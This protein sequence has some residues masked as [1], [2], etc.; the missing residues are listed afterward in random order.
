MSSNSPP[1]S[2]LALSLRP[3]IPRLPS[4]LRPRKMA[5]SRPPSTLPYFR[6]SQ[7]LPVSILASPS[8][9]YSLIPARLQRNR[10]RTI[11]SFTFR[12]SSSPLPLY[13]RPIRR[14]EVK[15]CRSRR[16]SS[17]PPPDR[18][19]SIDSSS[20]I[21]PLSEWETPRRRTDPKST[22][23][24]RRFDRKREPERLDSVVEDPR[25]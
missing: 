8:W 9:D 1:E 16:P 13:E 22:T 23:L 4:T 25:C 19:S 24:E 5:R 15:L 2:F 21:S 3:S 18:L 17:T 10:H 6:N 20:L 11:P 14:P 12:C 7:R